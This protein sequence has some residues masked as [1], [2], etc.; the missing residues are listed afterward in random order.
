MLM[1]GLKNF[2]SISLVFLNKYFSIYKYNSF[3]WKYKDFH[4]YFNEKRLSTKPNFY[5]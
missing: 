4:L 2:Y 3:F 1:K 5:N